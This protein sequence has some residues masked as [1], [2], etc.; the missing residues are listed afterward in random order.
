[1]RNIYRLSAHAMLLIGAA[2]STTASA[3]GHWYGR[4]GIGEA[5]GTYRVVFPLSEAEPNAR[6]TPGSF[7]PRVTQAN[8]HQTICVPG[9]S[10]SVRPPLS[11]TEALKRNLITAYGYTDRRLGDY[12]LD[13]DAA[14]GLG[15]NPTDARNLWPE[16]HHLVGGWGS[17]AKDR[18]EDRLHNLVCHDLV[19]LA[20]AQHDITYDWIAAYKTYVGPIPN[21]TPMRWMQRDDGSQRQRV[22]QLS[23][24]ARR[25]TR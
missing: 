21:N 6:L 2:L 8:I 22:D 11:Y 24:A 20:Q 7:D 3:S 23:P 16:P 1:M 5:E 15:G 9:Y 14:V 13:H 25:M 19:P 4:G 18:L 10:R 17:Y 12:E